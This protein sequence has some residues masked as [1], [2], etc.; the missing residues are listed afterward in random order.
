MEEVFEAA[1]AEGEVADGFVG[2]V[3]EGVVHCRDW[4]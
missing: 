3:L 2:G 1:E 4:D